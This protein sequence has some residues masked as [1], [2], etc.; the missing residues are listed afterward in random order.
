MPSP[1]RAKIGILGGTF[2]PVHLGHLLI[3]QDALEAAGLS[4]VRF[5]PSAAPPHKRVDLLAP[6]SQRLAMLKL[7]LRGNDRFTVDD[8]E[9]KRGGESYSVDTVL[10]LKSE[11]PQAEFHFIIGADS[12]QQLHTWRKIDTLVEACSFIAVTRPGFDGAGAACTKLSPAA[13]R[14]LRLRFLQGHACDI[15]SRDIRARI[16]RGQSVRYLVPEAVFR[17]IQRHSLYH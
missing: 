17:Y 4:S 8:R 5:I 9:I 12:L 6:A 10:E 13:R 15:A 2:N 1:Q 7:A 11:E 16:A 3:A 14:R